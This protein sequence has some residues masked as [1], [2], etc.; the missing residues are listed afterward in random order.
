[1]PDSHLEVA[2]MTP[3]GQVHRVP[4]LIGLVGRDYLLE[5]EIPPIGVRRIVDR[6]YFECLLHL[7]DEIEPLGY[8]LLVQGARRNAW[9]SGMLRDMGGGRKAYLLELGEHGVRP[10]TV[11]IFE[12]AH[13]GD[14]V[15]ADEQRD[16]YKTWLDELG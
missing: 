13:V 15:L 5:L 11:D 3:S 1:M 14:V 6:D 4:C 8:R 16:F 12:P 7:R 10:A 9:P 2:V